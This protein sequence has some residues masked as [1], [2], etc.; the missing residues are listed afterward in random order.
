MNPGVP[1]YRAT[2]FDYGA[3][4]L[5][6]LAKAIERAGVAVSVE[7]DPF[8]ALD[9]DLVVLPGVGAFGQAAERLSPARDRWRA[10]IAEGL[11]CLGVCLGMQLLLDSSEEGEGAG[12]GI[13]AGRVTRLDARRVPHMGWN[14][15]D[16]GSSLV[17]VTL[18]PLAPLANRDAYY[19]F[20]HGYACRLEDDALVT[21]WCRHEEDRFP[22]VIARGSV[23]GV[24]FHPEKSSRAGAAFLASFLDAV[25]LKR[26]LGD[27]RIEAASP[28]CAM[29][30]AIDETRSPA[31]TSRPDQ[32]V[33]G[34]A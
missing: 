23:L 11:P 9:T 4:N 7:T 24:Q 31:P 20:A 21:A 30:E 22:A 19:Y 1:R 18:R 34:I 5:H 32:N 15:L 26:A 3:G 13:F 16:A 27:E 2:I 29:S 25:A 17:S 12:L 33:G 28:P 14:T 6:S 10:R 8:R